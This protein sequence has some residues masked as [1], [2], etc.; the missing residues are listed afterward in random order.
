MYVPD[1]KLLASY[2]SNCLLCWQIP[3][4]VWTDF[5][6]VLASSFSVFNDNN[7]SMMDGL[8]V[9]KVPCTTHPTGEPAIDDDDVTSPQVALL[10]MI[11]WHQRRTVSKSRMNLTA[12]PSVL[13]VITYYPNHSSP[14]LLILSQSGGI[15][16]LTSPSLSL[17]LNHSTSPDNPSTLSL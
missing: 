8:V 2:K 1:I 15:S 4:F 7:R 13:T 17:L 11:S 3:V 10:R 12:R 9:V 16:A 5:C 6:S 14:S